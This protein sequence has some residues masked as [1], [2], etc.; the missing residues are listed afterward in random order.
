M[1]PI[2]GTPERP[3][4]VAIIGAGP[5][6]FY[7]ADHLLRN[8]K[9]VEVDLYDR[10]PTPYGLVRLGV[11]PDHQKIKFVTNVFDKMAAERDWELIF[12]MFHRQIPVYAR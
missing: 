2:P 9:V 10:L 4:R 3:L 6:G 5:T 7:T 1:T 8:A 12:A 11:A